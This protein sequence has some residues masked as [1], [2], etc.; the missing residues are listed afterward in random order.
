MNELLALIYLLSLTLAGLAILAAVIPRERPIPAEAWLPLGFGLGL[1]ALTFYLEAIMLAGGPLSPLALW[2]FLGAGPLIWLFLGRRLF[3]HGG[4]RGSRL[5][6]D[7]SRPLGL[8]HLFL[9]LTLL[10]VFGLAIESVSYP[11]D[12]Y[13]D[14]VLWNYKAKILFHEKTIFTEAFL[15][16]YRIHYHPDYPILIP[17]VEYGIHE[18]IGAVGERAP[19]P[20]FFCF[21]LALLGYSFHLLRRRMPAVWAAA[22]VFLLAALPIYHVHQRSLVSG[23]ADIPFSFFV[24]V[25]AFGFD[26]WWRRSRR[27]DLVLGALFLG[28]CIMTKKEGLLLF[29]LLALANL[30]QWIFLPRGPRRPRLAGWAFALL[31]ALAVALPWLLL[32]RHLPNYYD[33]KFSTMIRFENLAPAFLRIPIVLEAFVRLALDWKNWN[34]V[35]IAYLVIRAWTFFFPA[36]RRDLFLDFLIVIWTLAYFAVYLVT[37]LHVEFHL[38][39]SLERLMQQ[40]I[41][42]VFIRTAILAF[43]GPVRYLLQSS[44][45]NSPTLDQIPCR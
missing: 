29:A 12:L 26:A 45:I 16:P 28:L 1:G 25:A 11:L 20:L 18:W 17:L 36:T 37:P 10:V 21:A 30:R 42:L 23:Y 34:L 27:L 41:P 31:A 5:L 9:V 22:G 3:M 24:L 8:T 4:F 40:L 44:P 38:D 15:D 2:L 43:D 19:R 6:H 7:L 13:N 32:G 35:W 14:R 33:E 39:T